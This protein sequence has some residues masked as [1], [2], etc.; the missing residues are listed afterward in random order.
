MRATRRKILMGIG[1]L[2]II[3]EG[4]G[5]ILRSVVVICAFRGEIL[6]D[7]VD[8]ERKI[9]CIGLLPFILFNLV[10]K[11]VFFE[12]FELLEGLDLVSDG[13]LK[14]LRIII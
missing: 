7:G 3:R 13:E 1:M 8:A 9:H 10:S 6:L 2:I 14:L 11:L 12:I 5:I 4:D